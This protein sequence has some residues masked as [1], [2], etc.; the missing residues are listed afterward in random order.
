ME[1][2]DVIHLRLGGS[3][4]QRPLPPYHFIRG[5]SMKPNNNN[6]NATTYHQNHK[7]DDHVTLNHSQ[8]LHFRG[9]P[10]ILGFR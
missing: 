1:E 2:D 7:H 10:A 4:G 5:Q 9:A 8:S 6:N 3:P